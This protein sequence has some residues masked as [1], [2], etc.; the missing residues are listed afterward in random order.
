MGWSADGKAI[1]VV[2]ATDTPFRVIRV[3]VDG[4]PAMTLFEVPFDVDMGT[5]SPDG[6]KFVFTRTD[7][8]SDVWLAEN[9]D[10]AV[11]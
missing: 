6:T 3:P 7:T 11:W 10:P 2:D 4:G 8:T 1:Y 9:F 5:A